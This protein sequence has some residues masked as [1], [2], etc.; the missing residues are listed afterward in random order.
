LGVKRSGLEADKSPPSTAKV[1]SAWIY[2]STPQCVFMAW[3]LIKQRDNF[4]LTF[5]FEI[6][7][8][9]L[10]ATPKPTEY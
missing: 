7:G 10:D 1:K 8:K 3:Y 5:I 6:G 9:D 2:T 4:T